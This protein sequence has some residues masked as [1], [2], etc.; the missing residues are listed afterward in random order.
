MKTKL[1][2]VGLVA[3]AIVA[4]VVMKA[5]V[6]ASRQTATKIDDSSLY[7]EYSGSSEFSVALGS[8]HVVVQ[9]GGSPRLTH[10]KP[11]VI[12]PPTRKV[13][14]VA[15]RDVPVPTPAPA[16]PAKWTLPFSCGD[17]LYYSKRFSQAQL[18]VMR[19]AAGMAMPSADQRAQIQACLVGKIK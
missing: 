9:R 4:A 17:V 15:P 11:A 5:A 13:P 18:E 8:E 12:A 1:Y 6:V 3:A 19:R 14:L 7:S 16:A 10:M 2:L